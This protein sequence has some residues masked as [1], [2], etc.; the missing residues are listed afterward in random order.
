L[1]TSSSI[2]SQ[3]PACALDTAQ[4]RTSNRRSAATDKRQLISSIAAISPA[5]SSRRLFSRSKAHVNTTASSSSKY[6]PSRQSDV[7]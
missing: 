3:L 6:Q 4:R 7:R 1:A 5:T 2:V